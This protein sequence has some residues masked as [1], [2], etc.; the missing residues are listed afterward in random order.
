[1]RPEY[2]SLLPDVIKVMREVY[3]AT[4]NLYEENEMLNL[5]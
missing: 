5:P 3:D 4:Q 2:E 1:M